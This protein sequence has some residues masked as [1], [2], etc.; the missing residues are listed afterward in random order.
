MPDNTGDADNC[1]YEG[2]NGPCQ[3]PTHAKHGENGR[4]W[5][6]SHQPDGPDDEPDGRGASEGNFNAV[7]TGLHMSVKRRLEWFKEL[8]EPYLGLFEDYYVEYHGKAENKSEAAALASLAVIRDELQEHL[9]KDGVF[10]EEQIRDPEE[11]IEQGMDPGEAMDRCM[12]EK[13]KVGT[14]DAL[15]SV[16]KEVRLGLKYEGI[17]GGP[18]SSGGGGGVPDGANAMWEGDENGEV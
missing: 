17:S 4:C 15:D 12:V 2:A 1:G 7:D 14:L 16:S 9:L 3:N 13:P 6:K 5:L 18:S 8:G 10:Y 11:L